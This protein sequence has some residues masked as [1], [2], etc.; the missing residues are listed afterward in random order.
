MRKVNCSCGRKLYTNPNSTI[1]PTQCPNCM[2][3]NL[4]SGDTHAVKKGLFAKKQQTPRK[5]KFN[6]ETSI[7]NG[8]NYHSKLEASYAMQLDWRKKAG[9]IKNIIRQY[10]IDL[11]INGKHWRNYYIDFKVELID[12]T[13]EYIEVKGFPTEV[14][15]M[16]WDATILLFSEIAEGENAKLYLNEKLVKEIY[17]LI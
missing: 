9:E 17:N 3:K 15:K 5:N 2:F 12:G 6:A 16:K 10:R 4:V 1:Q 7:Y 11:R 8:V 14:W 13:F